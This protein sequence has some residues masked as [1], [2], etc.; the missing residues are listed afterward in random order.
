[1]LWDNRIWRGASFQIGSYTLTCKFEAL[2]QDFEC[3]LTEVYAPNYRHE[4]KNAKEEI[5][6]VRGLMGGPWAIC[7]DFN[8]TRFPSE[9]IKSSRRSPAI[10]NFSNFIEDMI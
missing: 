2:F 1:M 9:K 4:R 6:A 10:V 5:G 8:I 7:G 3:H